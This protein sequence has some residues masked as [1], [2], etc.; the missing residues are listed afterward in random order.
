MVIGSLNLNLSQISKFMHIYGFVDFNGF[1]DL[2][3]SDLTTDL[4]ISA[5]Q[6]TTLP[7]GEF[8]VLVATSLP[9]LGA[10]PICKMLSQVG[11]IASDKNRSR[12]SCRGKSLGVN[13]P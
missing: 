6:K 2:R 4:R 5:Y 12:R 11:K 1:V 7:V 3:I 13:V 8:L 10:E 9:K